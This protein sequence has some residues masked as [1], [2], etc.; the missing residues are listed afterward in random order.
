MSCSSMSII[1]QVARIFGVLWATLLIACSG[2][3][4]SK[5]IRMDCWEVH[6][7]VESS[8]VHICGVKFVRNSCRRIGV[9]DWTVW[10]IMRVD[11]RF[12]YLDRHNCARIE[13]DN[14]C[15]PHRYFEV[16]GCPGVLGTVPLPSKSVLVLAL[17]MPRIENLSL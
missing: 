5:T 15:D 12:L 16:F 14:L 2:V 7:E 3:I 1:W 17:I 10:K 8:R 4:E 13:I 9:V 6:F 11:E